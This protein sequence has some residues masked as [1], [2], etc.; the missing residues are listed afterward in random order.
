MAIRPTATDN[1]AFDE[2][3]K[4]GLLRE[5]S[6][7]S[8]MIALSDKLDGEGHGPANKLAWFCYVKERVFMFE[9]EKA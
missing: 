3:L 7:L 9:R 8:E 1:Q 6:M 4:S 5:N 2:L